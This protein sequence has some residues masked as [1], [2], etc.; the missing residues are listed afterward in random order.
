MKSLLSLSIFLAAASFLAAENW[1]AWRG[2]FA[3]S[4][5]TQE[6]DL[7]LKWGKEENV[8]W[9]VE[10][11]D[12]GNGTPIIYTNKV[13]VP[14]AKEA[15]N[16]RGLLCLDRETGNLL[17]ERGVT[18]KEKERT[19][20]DNPYC[21]SSPAADG[22][23]VVVPYGSAGIA[24]YD[25]DGNQL[26][27]KELGAI[28]HTWGNSSSPVFYD[29]LVI[30]YHGPGKGAKLVALKKSDGE[31]AWQFDEPKWKPGKRTD[32]FRGREDEGVI[33]SFSTPILINS[34]DRDE[35]VMSFPMEIKSFNPKTG[36]EL[37]RCEGLSPLVYASPVY[38]DGIVVAM[39]GYQGNSVGVKAGGAGDVT[40]TSRLWQI[41]RHN[42]GIGTGVVKDGYYYYQ[43]SGGVAYCLE[44]KSG[45]TKWEARLPGA[46]K[47][48]GSFMLAGDRIYSLSQPGDIVVFKASPD[49]L[50]VIAQS[51]L[52]ERTNS[53][54]VASDGDI[55]IRT[56]EALWCISEN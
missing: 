29:D 16:W 21:S 25:F 40:D 56:Y 54:P 6:T 38:G 31:I 13:F 9:R 34:G 19:H 18:Y 52:G 53:S 17:W 44:M 32:G 50:E 22:E 47:S 26:W 48:W 2:D 3:G 24:A 55:F 36:E 15:E 42:G 14:Q 33:G 46:G 39:G 43:N 20:R 4:G 28:D 12:R 35:L 51:D 23:M 8:K 49:G 45:E 41:E 27:F 11:P 30:H 10:L 5:V 37:W 1:P 7:P